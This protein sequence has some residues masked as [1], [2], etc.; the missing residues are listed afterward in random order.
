M[1]PIPPITQ[2]LMLACTAI[3]CLQA[4]TA[5]VE[6]FLIRWFAL[7]PVT[8]GYFLPWQ[9]VSYG[10][11]HGNLPHLLFNMLGLW[12]FGSELETLWGRKRY[13]AFVA[14]GAF[15]GGLSFVVATLIPG[16]SASFLVGI[17]GSLFA[18]LMA[19]AMY[20]P[21]RT[22]MLL[23][24][25]VPMKMKFMALGY[26]VISLVLSFTGDLGSL[27]HLGGML[28]GFLTIRYWRG[29]SPFKQRRR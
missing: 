20:F 22:V 16:V 11:L 14:I 2:F 4:L 12:M 18:L 10:L 6:F 19:T 23:L 29:Q 25:P 1:P 3:F 27:A 8:S 17:S 9:M 7:S 15:F 28:G 5:S 26:G 13:I 24:P 21:D